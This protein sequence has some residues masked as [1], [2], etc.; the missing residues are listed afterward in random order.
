MPEYGRAFD[1][2]QWIWG[3]LSLPPLSL[4]IAVVVA[5]NILLFLAR[6]AAAAVRTSVGEPRVIQDRH[7]PERR[8]LSIVA[9]VVTVVFVAE[10]VVRGYAL[11][12]SDVIHWW[13]FAAPI[14]GA[15]LGLGV[16]L[17]VITTRGTMPPA[18][19]VVSAA[20]RHGMSFSARSELLVVALVG[21]TLVA[22]TLLAGLASSPNGEGQY[23]WLAIPIPNE[24]EIDPLRLPFYGWTYGVPVLVCLAALGAVF[25]ATLARNAAR[26]FLRP[27]TVT[28]ERAARRATARSVAR[29]T[30]GAILLT[31]AGAWRLIAG[32]GPVSQ[33]TI[34]GQNAG[35]PYDATRRFAEFAVA[36]GWCAP[37]LEVTAFVLLLIVAGGGLHARIASPRAE[38]A[39]AA[40]SAR[41]AL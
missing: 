20:R 5:G 25:W 17:G 7:A 9:I 10:F 4:L 28:A 12:G 34:T 6:P 27:Q 38:N 41:T 22:T 21:A 35:A 8:T 26:P 14:A 1:S 24:A 39:E 30:T 23:V 2:A 15:A 31:L 18:A 19:P 36:A 37:L 40:A 13:R 33:L 3:A 29:V 32:T 11:T 16:V